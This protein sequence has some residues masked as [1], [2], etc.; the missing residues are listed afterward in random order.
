[1]FLTL[2]NWGKW[3]MN[4]FKHRSCCYRNEENSRNWR[5][6]G[7]LQNI[8]RS[9]LI[10]A[11]VQGQ[12]ETASLSPPKAT[13]K[14][15]TWT[16]HE[17]TFTLRKHARCWHA[18]CD[19]P[20]Q[21]RSLVSLSPVLASSRNRRYPAT[22]SQ[23]GTSIPTPPPAHCQTPP[24]LQKKSWTLFPWVEHKLACSRR[25]SRVEPKKKEEVI[26]LPMYGFVPDIEVASWELVS[27]VAMLKSVIWTWP[28]N[29]VVLDVNRIRLQLF[30]DYENEIDSHTFYSRK[31]IT[32]PFH[33][34]HD[35]LL[36]RNK[37][38]FLVK[39]SWIGVVCCKQM[40]LNGLRIEVVILL[41]SCVIYSGSRISRMK[42]I[43]LGT[44]AGV[45]LPRTSAQRATELWLESRSCLLKMRDARDG[46]ATS[47]PLQRPVWSVSPGET[48]PT[49][50]ESHNSAAFSLLG[51][52][53]RHQRVFFAILEVVVIFT[54]E[55]FH[56]ELKTNTKA[57]QPFNKQNFW[58]HWGRSSFH[59]HRRF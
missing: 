42:W 10:G 35:D 43:R 14:L 3:V 57:W 36:N 46:L 47:G 16:D 4:K 18:L 40:R 34:S 25:V 2:L 8:E 45:R 20:L 56:H 50:Y 5:R 24:G 27:L 49:L 26:T 41:Q 31:L 39:R 29:K 21:I 7:L 51:E 48:C 38:S 30:E 1:M 9:V 28:A 12:T 23:R 13:H 33:S 11:V 59:F 58:F 52:N 37:L 55:R 53:E 22:T 17:K 19:T 6:A 44:P 32:R 54:K 15:S